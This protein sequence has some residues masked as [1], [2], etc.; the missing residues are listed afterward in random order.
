M[1]G[2]VAT[3]GVMVVAVAPVMTMM[4]VGIFKTVEHTLEK[5][6]SLVDFNRHFSGGPLPKFEEDEITEQG[7]SANPECDFMIDSLLTRATPPAHHTSPT[8]EELYLWSIIT[9]VSFRS[10]LLKDVM[11]LSPL[12]IRN[13]DDEF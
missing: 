12:V 6:N 4:L 5:I 2:Y 7:G 11:I 3:A 1:G 9:F 10:L 8:V 13:A